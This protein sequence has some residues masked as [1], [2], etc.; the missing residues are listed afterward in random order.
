MKYDFDMVSN[1]RDTDSLK[2]DTTENGLSMCGAGM[3]FTAAPEVRSVV[4]GLAGQGMFG[5]QTIPEEWY[6]AYTGWWKERHGFLMEKDWFV[7]CSG[8]VP[9]IS[10]II[11]KLTTPAE[12]V[13]LL[14]P[15]Y[16]SLFASIVDNGRQ[17]LESPL[18]YDGERYRADFQDLERKLADPQTTLMI[19]CNPHDP[20]GII[21][22][23]EMLAGVG[24]LCVKY[25]VTVIADENG[26]DLTA[27]GRSYIP[28]ASVSEN[29][30]KNSITCI[31]PAKA[32]NLAGLQTASVVVPDERLRHKV[33]RGLNTDA[34]AS[35]N[36]FRQRRPL[37]PI[38]GGHP[39]WM[40]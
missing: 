18:K 9:A 37:P 17:V 1:R 26:C 21:W 12:Q 7:F 19:L 11:R 34:V 38:P 29:C 27:P 15:V 16:D 6:Q 25:H 36:T 35:P 8:V 23:R 4:E 5:E 39:G 14:T 33:V 30:R 2:W 20:A 28:F 40:H 22:D 13:L 24:E 32:F 31:S 3:V 10:G